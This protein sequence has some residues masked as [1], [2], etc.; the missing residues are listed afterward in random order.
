MANPLEELKSL[1]AGKPDNTSGTVI[2]MQGS[3]VQLRTSKGIQLV[4]TS[5]FCP[6]GA[7][8]TV[9]STGKVLTVLDSENSIPEYRV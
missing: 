4:N 1:I 3:L 5:K 9:D 6:Q 8:L 7:N 2:G